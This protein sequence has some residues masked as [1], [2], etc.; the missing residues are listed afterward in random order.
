MKTRPRSVTVISWI[1]IVLGVLGFVSTIAMQNDPTA[2]ELM[3]KSPISIPVQIALN[4][5]GLVVTIVSGAVMLKGWNWGRLLYV[6]W[7]AISFMIGVIT[8]PVKWALIPGLVIF[9]VLAFFLFRPKANEYFS[10]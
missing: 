10:K 9:L 2:L 3:G 7:S 8:S 4:Y 5:L 1:L 6:G